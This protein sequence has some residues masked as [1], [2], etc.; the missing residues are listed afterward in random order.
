MW[1]RLIIAILCAAVGFGFRSNDISVAP[2]TGPLDLNNPTFTGT[3]TGPILNLTGPAPALSFNG[4]PLGGSCSGTEFAYGISAT[5][6][7]LCA[8]P[9]GG[10]GGLPTPVSILNGGLGGNTVPSAG[11]LLIAVSPTEYRPLTLSGNAT[12]N[13]TGVLTITSL[14]SGLTINNATFTGVINLPNASITDAMLVNGYSGIGNCPASQFVTGLNRNAAPTCAP[15]LGGVVVSNIAP[16]TPHIGMLWFDTVSLQTYIWYQNGA[17]AKWVPTINQPTGGGGPG[18]AGPAT[19]TVSATAPGSP[20]DGM[21]WFNSSNLQ[22]FIRY[23]D[24]TSTQ[25]VPVIHP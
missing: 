15:A 20:S 25:W 24:G 6:T 3:M 4:V 16:A 7:P 19:V 1:K 9:A 12:I 8:T 5:G 17:S 21:L 18:P 11:Q 23:N 2:S 14:P 10:G 13:S 22:M